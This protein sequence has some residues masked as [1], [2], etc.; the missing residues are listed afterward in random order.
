MTART[1]FD[2][3]ME[4]Q[5]GF[6]NDLGKILDV[7]SFS[8]RKG[9]ESEAY[10]KL[11]LAGTIAAG[12]GMVMGAF[13]GAAGASVLRMFGA[14]V[15]HDTKYEFTLGHVE[16]LLATKSAA[17]QA[18]GRW[19]EKAT[20]IVEARVGEATQ[21]FERAYEGH[22]AR[23]QRDIDELKDALGASASSKEERARRSAGLICLLEH[24]SREIAEVERHCAC[25]GSA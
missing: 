22:V 17:E 6:V 11:A 25:R 14:R 8:E 10:Q 21:R 16:L 13:V 2:M 19:T 24:C 12:T 20:R 1:A 4:T 15:G 7:F 9:F 5:V 3:V 18:S 23:I